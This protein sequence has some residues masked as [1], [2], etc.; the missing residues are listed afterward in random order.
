MTA[1]VTFGAGLTMY[2][3]DFVG[4]NLNWRGLPFSW[5]ASGFDDSSPDGGDFPDEQ[6]D[7]SDRFFRL[8]HMFTVGVV[9]YLP[10]SPN[11]TE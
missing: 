2:F 4:L 1:A 7:A 9:I 8:N 6:V 11:I 3:N 10:T 5:N